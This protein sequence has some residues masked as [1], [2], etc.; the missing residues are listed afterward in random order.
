MLKLISRVSFKLNFDI[1]NL[2]YT[3]IENTS[4]K[5]IEVHRVWHNF[6]QKVIIGFSFECLMSEL[7]KLPTAPPPSIPRL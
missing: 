2:H 4:P 5:S 6:G 7:I 1:K 3:S